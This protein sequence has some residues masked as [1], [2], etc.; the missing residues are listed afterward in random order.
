M[1]SFSYLLLPIRVITQHIGPLT[2][3]ETCQRYKRNPTAIKTQ[4]QLA[5]VP[6]MRERERDSSPSL[7]SILHSM[8]AN[9][10]WIHMLQK[11]MHIKELCKGVV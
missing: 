4:H 1:M 7:H 3:N 10:K 11:L 9:G 5:A 8:L 2:L 6:Q